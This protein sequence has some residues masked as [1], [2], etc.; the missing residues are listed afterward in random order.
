MSRLNGRV[1]TWVYLGLWVSIIFVWAWSTGWRNYFI[2]EDIPTLLLLI[3]VLLFIIWLDS[4]HK[5]L[6]GP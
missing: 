4:R 6:F 2:R 5:M 3:L 1:L